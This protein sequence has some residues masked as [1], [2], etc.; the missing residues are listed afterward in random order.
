[1]NNDEY[2][3]IESAY[4]EKMDVIINEHPTNSWPEKYINVKNKIVLDIGCGFFGKIIKF[5]EGNIELENTKLSNMI[6][7]SEWFLNLGAKKVIGLDMNES[8]IK[9]LIKKLEKTEKTLFF[10]DTINSAEQLEKLI[11]NYNVEILKIDIEGGEVHLLDVN[12]DIFS[13]VEE[14]YVETHNPKIHSDFIKKFNDCHYNIKGIMSHGIC[15]DLIFANKL[16]L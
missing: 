12:N 5:N 1:M 9:H 7:T 8:D 3:I 13:S 11:T 2:T 15:P 6:S 4:K 10:N 16:K 14:Y